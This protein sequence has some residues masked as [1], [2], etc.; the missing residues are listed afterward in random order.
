MFVLQQPLGQSREYPALS[1]ACFYLGIT[2]AKPSDTKNCISCLA[3]PGN[4]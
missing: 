2:V 3:R 1:L 4:N